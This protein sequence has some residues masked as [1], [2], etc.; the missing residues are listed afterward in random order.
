M[1]SKMLIAEFY[2]KSF[3]IEV[4]FLVLVPSTIAERKTHKQTTNKHTHD[5]QNQNNQQG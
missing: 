5:E 4:L 2:A 1:P 3:E